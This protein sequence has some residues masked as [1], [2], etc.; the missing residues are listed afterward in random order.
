[1]PGLGALRIRTAPIILEF[2]TESQGAR[3]NAVRD[4]RL[5]DLIPTK[6]AT[7]ARSTLALVLLC[8][9]VGA[10]RAEP[11]PAP[12]YPIVLGWHQIVEDDQPVEPA[13]PVSHLSDFENVLKWL[14]DNG[15][16]TLSIDEY[17]EAVRQPSPPRDAVLLTVDDGYRSVYT[18]LF[19]L[20][21]RY[22]MHLTAFVITERVG[23]QNTVNPHQP[24][25]NWDECREMTESGLVDIEAHAAR[26]HQQIKGKAGRGVVMG[27]WLTTRLFDPKTRTLETEAAYEK[28][29][30][31]EFVNV[32]AQLEAEMGRAPRTF[33]WPYGVSNDFARKAC[34]DAGFEN[35]FTLKQVSA[36]PTCRRRY[37]Y[38]EESKKAYSAITTHPGAP[39]EG[40]HSGVRE[41]GSDTAESAPGES[42]PPASRVEAG[43]TPP[44][45]A[46]RPDSPRP[47]GSILLA[48][49]GAA[50]VWGVL[51]LLLFRDGD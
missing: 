44:P 8:A 20:L 24:W 23:Q 36:D 14:R 50:A 40:P 45:P 26:S 15:V 27:P 12:Q 37:H 31:E 22:N 35:S 21:K 18:E 25:L 7:V 19:P 28:R 16:R 6:E 33:C 2:Q 1:M 17:C 47:V 4:D 46:R 3:R 51:Y 42:H 13:M 48:A 29:V 39:P 32:R 34:R 41:V 11:G 38:P 49:A 30:R 9:L 5:A 43:S 10:V